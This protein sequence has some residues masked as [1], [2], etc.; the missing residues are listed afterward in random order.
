MN[1]LFELLINGNRSVGNTEGQERVVIKDDQYYILPWVN[2][3]TNTDCIAF[4]RYRGQEKN[5]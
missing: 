3:E 4:F 5:S 2:S 1:K